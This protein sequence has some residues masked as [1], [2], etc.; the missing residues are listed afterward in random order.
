MTARLPQAF[1]RRHLL[2]LV[3]QGVEP[4]QVAHGNLQGRENGRREKGRAQ[5]QA[6]CVLAVAAQ[7]P[8]GREAG[9]EKRGGEPGCQ[10][11]VAKAVG[12][13][14]VEHHGE[15]VGG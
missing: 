8:I 15:P 5:R 10:Q 7:D 6:W 9:D 2:R 4:V 12:Q 11:R 3:L 13:G 1:H 14:G